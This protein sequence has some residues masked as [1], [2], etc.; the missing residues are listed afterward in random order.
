MPRFLI[1]RSVYLRETLY[2]WRAQ[3]YDRWRRIDFEA[4]MK[5]YKE[6]PNSKG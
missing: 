1:E 3:R 6:T 4:T 2:Q 5:F